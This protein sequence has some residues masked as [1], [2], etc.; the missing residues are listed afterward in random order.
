M[1][2]PKSFTQMFMNY[3]IRGPLDG[4]KPL[5]RLHADR[6]S[7]AQMGRLALQQSLHQCQS[8]SCSATRVSSDNTLARP[9]LAPKAHRPMKRVISSP[10]AKPEKRFF[11]RPEELGR[12]K[13]PGPSAQFHGSRGAL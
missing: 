5:G 11:K 1:G 7:L 4:I 2:E 12:R 13:I 6:P 8:Q 10:R 9:D 3:G